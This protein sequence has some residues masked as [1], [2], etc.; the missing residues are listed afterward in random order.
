M[1]QTP[2]VSIVMAVCNGAEKLADSIKSVLDQGGVSLEFI[3]LNDGSGEET[4]SILEEYASG[5]RRIRL[6]NRKNRGLTQSLI[7]GCGVASGE[8]IARQ[9]VGDIYLP[10]KLASQVKAMDDNPEVAMV[11]CGTRFVGPR[12]EFLF[13]VQQ[14]SNELQRGLASLDDRLTGPSHHCSVVFRRSAYEEAGG[15]RSQ[16][17][18]AQDLDL[19]LRLSELGKVKA[20]REILF[21]AEFAPN[22]LS[23]SLRDLQIV[24]TSILVECA[25]RRRQGEDEAPLL[26]QADDK[27][28]EDNRFSRRRVAGASYFIARILQQNRDPR[29][30][31]Y[32]NDA[33]RNNPFHWRAVLASIPARISSSRWVT[34]TSLF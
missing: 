11:S 8:Y 3:I 9:D 19:W 21:E 20:I 10:N 17:R 31:E 13:Q 16:F 4:T 25:K 23:G 12:R 30:I 29:C 2:E 1:E 22:T 28:I 18:V 15:Y 14:S 34:P 24:L 26:Q 27:K 7:E 33:I 32:F 5:D 6:L